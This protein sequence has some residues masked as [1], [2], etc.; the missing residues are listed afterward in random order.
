MKKLNLIIFL[1]CLF[2]L[3][4]YAQRTL[5]T[6]DN[7][8]YPIG[9]LPTIGTSWSNFAD[10]VNNIG[11]DTAKV[12]SGNLV[13]PNYPMPSSGN[14]LSIVHLEGEHLVIS[15]LY[16]T[17]V[18]NPGDKIYASFLLQVTSSVGLGPEGTEEPRVFG[19]TSGA[20]A[21]W[22][23]LSTSVIFKNDTVGGF[24]NRA[25]NIGL[26]KG[27]N[28]AIWSPVSYNYGSA[29][30]LLV[31]NYE[32]VAGANSN[33]TARLW[34]N[35]DLS[36][37][38][39]P[40]TIIA[41]GR[42]NNGDDPDSLCYF[43]I[44]TQEGSPS[45]NVDAIRIA[46]EWNQAPL[47]VELSQFSA[48]INGTSVKLDWR[49]ET[50]VNDYGF[51]V[52]RCMKKERGGETWETIGFVN[53]NGNSN[54]PKNYFFEDTDL[55]YG[56]YLY[57]LKE[58]DNDGQFEYSKIIE[59]DIS[60]PDKFEL[61]QN[62]PNPFNPETKIQFQLPYE[63][64]VSLKIYDILGSEIEELI[65]ESKQPGKYEVD[66]NAS[67]LSSGTYFYRLHTENFTETKEMVLLK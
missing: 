62:Y 60:I 37:P 44:R 26:I 59:V 5:P 36:G 32:F 2:N 39:P 40:A 16:F 47:P 35:P 66:F 34:I 65:N 15:T 27:A 63:S 7:F 33:D 43:F 45:G 51:G 52:E 17:A 50:E 21:G 56:K 25:F 29:T 55:S 30:I 9:N 12:I 11:K 54:S 38:E 4:N 14:R 46:T 13:Y 49:T 48:H 8:D 19:F 18:K 31:L 28:P 23:H 41:P 3:Y 6:T 20:L 10:S 42:S 22:S 1:I 64:E 67:N 24:N 58:I 57:R 53:G 61:S